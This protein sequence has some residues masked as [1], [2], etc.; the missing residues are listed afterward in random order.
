MHSLQCGAMKSA[1]DTYGR[2]KCDHGTST[3]HR[4]RLRF[5]RER[6]ARHG[7]GRDVGRRRLHRAPRRPAPLLLLLAGRR[8]GSAGG[9]NPRRAP[10]PTSRAVAAV[11]VPRRPVASRRPGSVGPSPRRP[12]SQHLGL[13]VVVVGQIGRKDHVGLRRVRL[14]LLHGAVKLFAPPAAAGSTRR[15]RVASDVVHVRVMNWSLWAGF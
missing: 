11:V 8:L 15:A 7:L 13:V 12:T 14:E 6:R 2:C 5:T 3:V 10:A 4:S 9:Q 1:Y